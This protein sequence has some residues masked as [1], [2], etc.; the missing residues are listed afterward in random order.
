MY[1]VPFEYLIKM[2]KQE[3][4]RP[5]DVMITIRRHF[6]AYIVE[7]SQVLSECVCNIFWLFV[8][9]LSRPRKYI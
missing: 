8:S 7:L 5:R 2:S 6:D 3:F 1:R 4:E 9:C